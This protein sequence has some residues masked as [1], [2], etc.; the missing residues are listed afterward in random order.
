MVATAPD[1]G[2]EKM[3]NEMAT[4]RFCSAFLYLGRKRRSFLGRG[5]SAWKMTLQEERDQWEEEARKGGVPEGVLLVEER[6]DGVNCLWIRNAGSEDDRVALYVHGGGLVSGSISTHRSFAAALCKASGLAIL[7]AEYRLL[8]ENSFP[9]PLEDLMKVYQALITR[10]GVES[11]TL[12]LVGDSSGGGLVLAALT[13]LREL[14][15]RMPAA[16]IT[17]SGVFD[18]TLSGESLKTNA[19]REPYLTREE[20]V[21]WQ[22][23]YFRNVRSPLLSPLFADLS[24]LPP[25]LLLVGGLE[26]W[27][28]DSVRMAE[29]IRASGGVARLRVWDS[30]WHV[31]A[32]YLELKESE[33]A[34]LEIR[35]F[36]GRC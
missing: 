7:V 1:H 17:I 18:M 21:D 34:L 25:L 24:G 19:G 4:L 35:E 10:K 36:I 5:V 28:S 30:M 22:Q 11:K 12:F 14:G 6:I 29:K 33:E 13:R 26:L 8:P 32:M 15:E 27:L 3:Q 9:A 31:W 16:A 2:W 20:L 23:T